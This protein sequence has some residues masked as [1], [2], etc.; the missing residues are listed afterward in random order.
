MK[1]QRIVNKRLLRKVAEEHCA[2]CFLPGP[3][4]PCHIKSK[5]AGGPDRDWNVI[6]MCRNHHHEQHQI[7]ILSFIEKYP[8]FR[9]ALRIRGWTWDHGKLWNEKLDPKNDDDFDPHIDKDVN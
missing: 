5:G 6:A 2:I 7:G 8:F 3:S 9:L 4:D 1:K